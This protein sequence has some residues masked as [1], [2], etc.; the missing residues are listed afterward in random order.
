[1]M[2]DT[3]YTEISAGAVAGAAAILP[4]AWRG[5]IFLKN[6][7]AA[8]MVIAALIYVIFALAGIAAGTATAGWF[9][10]EFVGL[11]LFLIP[12]WLGYKGR[13]LALAFGWLLHLFWDAALH[14]GPGT[15]FVPGHYPGFCVGF[16]L[17]FAAFI[18]YYFGFR[19]GV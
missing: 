18:A 9:G 3:V 7:F 19:K 16:D 5:R 15:Q 13:P 4:F 11:L 1:M 8:T 17:V 2:L 6:Y 12:A 10:T 14:G